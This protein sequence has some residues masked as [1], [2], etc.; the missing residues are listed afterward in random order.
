MHGSQGLA[1]N[2]SRLGRRAAALLAA[3]VLLVAACSDS[4]DDPESSASS[5]TAAPQDSSTDSLLGPLDEAVGEPVRIGFIGDGQSAAGEVEIQVAEAA[6][7]YLNSHRGGIA[8]RPIEL[9]VC[10]SQNDPARGTD[11][12]NQMVEEGVALVAVGATGVYQNLWE[13]LHAAGIP[14]F[15]YAASGDQILGDTEATF[16][17]ATP[18]VSNAAF[19]IG[20][21]EQEGAE[22]VTVI[23]IDVPVAYAGY[24]GP[25][26]ELYADAGIDVEVVRVPVGTADMTPQLQSVLASDPGVVHVVGNDTFC[27]AAFQAMQA[28]AFDGPITAISFCL[29]DATRQAF[30]DGYLEGV[31]LALTSPTGESDASELFRE[32]VAEFGSDA[33]DIS[34]AGAVNIFV[35]FAGI[36]VALDGLEGEVTPASATAA[37]RSMDDAEL[38]GGGGLRFRCD[39]Q[40]IPI[41]PAACTA[42]GLYTVLDAAGQPTE[43]LP[44]PTSG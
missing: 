15:F 29:S 44:T 30:P 8:G 6:V 36:D 40:Q 4:D 34:R 5:T 10:R 7:A 9:V 19:P 41:E 43:T 11:C 3:S 16:A 28:L 39:G 18:S 20:I 26:G 37:M 22:K 33:I 2:V 35:L 38:P 12:G 32:V 14:T 27:I 24:D 23:A 21:A 17:L 1:V 13:P 42:Q 25:L 31:N